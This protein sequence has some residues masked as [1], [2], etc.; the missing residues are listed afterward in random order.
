MTFMTLRLTLEVE[1][2]RFEAVLAEAQK[3]CDRVDKGCR[4]LVN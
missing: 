1:D 4:I 2:E 3:C